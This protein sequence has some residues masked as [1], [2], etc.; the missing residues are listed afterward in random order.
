MPYCKLVLQQTCITRKH[1]KYAN[2]HISRYAKKFPDIFKIVG[3]QCKE[4]TNWASHRPMEAVNHLQLAT[5]VF[6][7]E[8]LEH[9]GIDKTLHEET[10]ILW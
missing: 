9:S 7:C 5:Q 8:V 6:L 3:L 10:S 1:S 2:T 4:D